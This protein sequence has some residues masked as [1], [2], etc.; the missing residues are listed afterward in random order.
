MTTENQTKTKQ[1]G[2]YLEYRSALGILLFFFALH[3][4]QQIPSAY[5]LGLSE[6]VL[7]YLKSRNLPSRLRVL[8]K[9]LLSGLGLI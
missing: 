1:M 7:P 3:T 4:T 8:F 5:H 2:A 6:S 9:T